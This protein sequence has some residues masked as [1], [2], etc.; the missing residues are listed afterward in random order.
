MEMLRQMTRRN[1]VA[2]HWRGQLSPRECARRC[3]K[4]IVS[5]NHLSSVL[6]PIQSIVPLCSLRDSFRQERPR[7][8]RTSCRTT[9]TA[10]H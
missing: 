8:A 6:H 10:G 9:P 7:I 2:G 3:G 1:G 5:Y 4:C